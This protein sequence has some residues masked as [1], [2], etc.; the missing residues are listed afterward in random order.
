MAKTIL[1]GYYLA[2]GAAT[3]TLHSAAGVLLG[4]LISHIQAG[5]QVVDFYDNTSAANP[6]ILSVAVE[7][8]ESPVYIRFAR[9]EGIAFSTG[10]HVDQGDC[11]VA[12]WSVDHG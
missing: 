8:T 3:E 2:A 11:K 1:S 12:V 6:K 10:L 9:N 7:P 5:V 4:F